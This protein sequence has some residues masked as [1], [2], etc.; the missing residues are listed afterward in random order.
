[1]PID[2]RMMR[3]TR[4]SRAKTCFR[5]AS[6]VI[7][8]ELLLAGSVYAQVSPGAGQIYTPGSSIQHPGDTGVKAHTNIQIF[9]P[10]K[11]GG[12]QVPP[13]NGAS[14]AAT[15]Q[16]LKAPVTNGVRSPAQ[17]H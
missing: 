8:F 7:A 6:Q 12:A 17:S 14:G 1:M 5:A 4:W 13:G 11:N 3:F 2:V 16:P 15:P 10:N 9:V